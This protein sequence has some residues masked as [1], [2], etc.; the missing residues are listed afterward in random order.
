MRV[1]RLVRVEYLVR[2]DDDI[3]LADKIPCAVHW[4]R[5]VL[6][7]D[8]IR[9]VGGDAA[10]GNNPDEHTSTHKH[11]Q[12][13]RN[14]LVRNTIMP[15]NILSKLSLYFGFRRDLLNPSIMLPYSY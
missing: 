4:N 10:T 3:V 7:R 9:Q 8:I 15:P 13:E 1:L 6:S 2:T 5:R 12:E 14:Q 11:K